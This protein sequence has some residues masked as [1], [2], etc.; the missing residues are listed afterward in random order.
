MKYEARRV[1]CEFQ[2]VNEQLGAMT[3]RGWQLVTVVNPNDGRRELYFQREAK[4]VRLDVVDG[5]LMREK[6]ATAE[7]PGEGWEARN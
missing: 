7:R 5:F 2:E 4:P 6:P 3:A 1:L